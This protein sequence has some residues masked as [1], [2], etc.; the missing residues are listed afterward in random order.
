MRTQDIERG[1]LVVGQNQITAIVELQNNMIGGIASAE[2]EV[3]NTIAAQLLNL[4]QALVLQML[5]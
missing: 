4:L 5:P 3:H 2:L 1:Q